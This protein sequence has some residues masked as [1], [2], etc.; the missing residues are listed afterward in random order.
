MPNPPARHLG[1]DALRILTTQFG[2]EGKPHALHRQVDDQHSIFITID[3][4]RPRK[5]DSSARLIIGIARK[6]NNELRRTM[7]QPEWETWDKTV[8]Q[9]RPPFIEGSPPTLFSN[10]TKRELGLQEW[11]DTYMPRLFDEC[12][13]LPFIKAQLE[14]QKDDKDFTIRPRMF[15][16][17]LDG[18]TN[19]AEVEFLDSFFIPRL[20]AVDGPERTKRQAQIDRIRAWIAEHPDGIERE[21]TD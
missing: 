13:N 7:L 18:W 10:V 4:W 11:L 21:L 2:F 3:P 6:D 19:E 8:V 5:K 15:E 9:K 17:M 1:K 16:E 12:A 14:Q 20:H